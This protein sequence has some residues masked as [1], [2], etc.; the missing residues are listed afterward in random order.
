MSHFY[1]SMTG[2]RGEVTRTGTKN[3]GMAVHVRGWDMGIFVDLIHENGVD[4]AVVYRTSGSNDSHPPLR[5]VEITALDITQD[6][7]VI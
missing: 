1:G 6:G 2:G 3:S 5:L 4:K 7:A